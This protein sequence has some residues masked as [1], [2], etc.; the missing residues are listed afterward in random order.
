M[1]PVE[2]FQKT[3]TK[4]TDILHRHEIRFHL[5]GGLTGTAYGEPRMTQDIDIVVDPKRIERVLDD[6]IGSLRQTDFIY[7][8]KSIRAAV[9]Q[10]GLFQLLDEE[11]VLKLDLYPRELI[12]GELDRSESLELFEGHWLPVVSRVDAVLSK[13]VWVSRGSHKSRRDLRAIN[14]N[15]SSQQRAQIEALATHLGL[16]GLL[17]DVLNETDEI[18]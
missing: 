7:D 15:A 5:T 14:R 4:L 17:V 2:V 8:E 6:F 9:E 1:F 18:D 12:A 13:L 11:E 10:G 16:N 3:L